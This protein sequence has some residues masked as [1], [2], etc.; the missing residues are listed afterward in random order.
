M[1]LDAT[2]TT[3]VSALASGSTGTF[4]AHPGGDTATYIEVTSTNA[5]VIQ[6]N[7]S[8]ETNGVITLDVTIALDDVTYQAAS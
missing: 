1:A 7:I 5:T 4:E 6:S 2:D 3:K 8:A